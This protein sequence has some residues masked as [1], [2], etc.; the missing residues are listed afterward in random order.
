MHRPRALHKTVM[1]AD[2]ISQLPGESVPQ[3]P[4]VFDPAT[5]LA[6]LRSGGLSVFALSRV[7]NLVTP[8]PPSLRAARE[9][10]A[11]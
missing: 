8:T 11:A 2:N 4:E 9:R 5:T 3:H 7:L 1:H 6:S 10:V